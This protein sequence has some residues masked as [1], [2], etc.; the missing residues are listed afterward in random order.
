MFSFVSENYNR[1]C[2]S[3]SVRGSRDE[4]MLRHGLLVLRYG[5]A[6]RFC[7]PYFNAIPTATYCTVP[8]RAVPYRAVPYR[9]VPCRAISCRAIPCR[10]AP[11]RIVACRTVP[12]RIVP[13]LTASCRA[14]PCRNVPRHTKPSQVRTSRD[15]TS[16]APTWQVRTG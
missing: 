4:S 3:L 14:V 7:P 13:N 10:A 1:R 9:A 5:K 8:H 2:H 12:F 11:Y 15:H 6:L 16:N